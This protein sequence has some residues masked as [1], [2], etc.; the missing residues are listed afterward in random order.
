[1]DS[2]KYTQLLEQFGKCFKQV[3]KEKG[4]TQLDIEVATGINNGDISRIENGKTNIEFI[5]IAKLA[6]ALDVEMFE[7]FHFETAISKKEK[8]NVQTNRIIKKKK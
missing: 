7:L 1:M 6:E 2:Q 8:G 5:T 4:K 3:R